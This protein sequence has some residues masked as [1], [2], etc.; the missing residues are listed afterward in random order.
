MVLAHKISFGWRSI[1]SLRVSLK[2]AERRAFTSAFQDGLWDIFI[3]CVLLVFAVAPVL[4]DRMGDVKST[5]VFVLFLGLA[6]LVLGLVK[7]SVVMPRVGVVRFGLARKAKLKRLYRMMLAVNVGMLVL[8]AYGIAA[9]NSVASWPTSGFFAPVVLVGF[10]TAAYFLDFRRLYAYGVLIAASPLVGEL[11]HRYF[12]APHSGIPIA[13][14]VAAT[15]TVLVGLA[16]FARMLRDSHA[17]G[18]G[19]FSEGA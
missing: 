17:P 14:G 9:S 8:G 19:P 16:I 18:S 4:S 12:D 13:F 6:G 3:G 15:I 7:K 10:G 1:M 5:A 2:E 11:L